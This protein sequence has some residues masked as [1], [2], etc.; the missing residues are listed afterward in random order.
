MSTAIKRITLRGVSGKGFFAEATRRGIEVKWSIKYT[1][2]APLLVC[3]K[4][5]EKI[6][7]HTE[8]HSGINYYIPRERESVHGWLAGG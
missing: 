4:I 2:Q 5:P 1:Y 6:L 7:H 3:S 8:R